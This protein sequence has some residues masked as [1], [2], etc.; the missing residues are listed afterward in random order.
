MSTHI[1]SPSSFLRISSFRATGMAHQLPKCILQEGVEMQIDKINNT[2]RRT[3]LKAVKVA[4]KD[5]YEEVLKDPFF[6]PFLAIIE[7]NLIY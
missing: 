1:A 2:C 3:L 4:L 6:G 7:N 5:K